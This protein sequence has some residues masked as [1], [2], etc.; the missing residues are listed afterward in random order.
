MV[1]IK[2]LIK[3]QKNQDIK[4]EN[5]SLNAEENNDDNSF[6]SSKLVYAKA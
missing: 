4:N 2:V 6:E 5:V 3:K 1:I